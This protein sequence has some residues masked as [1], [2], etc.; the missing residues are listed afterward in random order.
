MSDLSNIKI[1]CDKFC[2]IL[3]ALSV[4]LTLTATILIIGSFFAVFFLSLKSIPFLKYAGWLIG[5]ILSSVLLMAYSL[6][7]SSVNSITPTAKI[8]LLLKSCLA[9]LII[10][11]SAI[12]VIGWMFNIHVVMIDALELGNNVGDKEKYEQSISSIMC[13]IFYLI[14]LLKLIM[15]GI[16]SVLLFRLRHF[17]K[18][19]KTLEDDLGISTGLK[20]PEV[21][22][23]GLY[24]L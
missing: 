21:A 6:N 24:K 15:Y 4:I 20:I 17:I 2:K 5:E 7:I 22:P 19:I 11:L 18:Y 1:K 23:K 14:T 3:K 13:L 8:E 9:V 12:L 16:V 10:Q